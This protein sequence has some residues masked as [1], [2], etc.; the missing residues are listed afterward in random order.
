[1]ESSAGTGTPQPKYCSVA[2]TL[3]PPSWTGPAPPWELSCTCPFAIQEP[4]LTRH[5]LLTRYVSYQPCLHIADSAWQGPGWLGRVGDA[6]DTW[7]LA[8]RGPDGF[9]YRA[10]RK[11][12]P[13][14]ERQGALLVEF[15]VPLITD[16]KLP[17]QWQSMVLEEDV[18]QC[19]PT[20]DYSLEPG[21]KVLAPWEPDQQRYGPGTVLLGSEAREPQQ[22]SKGGEITVHFWNG[23]TATVPLG[24]VQWVPLAVWKKAVERLHKPLIQEH[25]RPLLW[26]PCCS[27]W[28]PATG[29]V[30]SG[31][32]LGTPFPCP[33]CVPPAC[34]Q[35]LCQ[36]CLCCCSLAGPTWWPLT[37][38][39]GGTAKEC[40][41]VEPKPPTQLL[42]LVHPKEDEASVRA[43]LGVSS[44]SSSSSEKDLE[45]DLQMGLPQRLMVDGTVNTDLVLPE[46][47]P[48]RQG[49]L[50]QPG[51]RYWR[52]GSEP[53][54][55]K[56]GAGNGT[57]W[58]EK[59]SNKEQRVQAIVM[60]N[61]R[62]LVLE[63]NG[64]KPPHIL[65]Q[66]EHRKQSQ[67]TATHQRDQN[68]LRPKALRS[69]VKSRMAGKGLPK[70]S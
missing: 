5:N 19:L 34:C 7:V 15:E 14:L 48:R 21:D 40:S 2:T 27:L 37:R 49:G 36:G 47:C 43:P 13:E 66:D 62:E 57:I 44:S 6:A 16:P 29:C 53:H 25:P 42:P 50:H 54:P 52:N 8:R 56:L 4:W 17:A 59:R 39:S 20:M 69:Q 60:G 58:K 64:V 1:M 67:A 46:K 11:A 55:G 65:P 51:W 30:T 9:Y 35:L 18:I 10:Q 23:N 28:G 12:A 45:T 61:T 70:D 38:T 33:P 68:A 31:P 32:S 24:R 22:A 41:E 26:A 3:K 63:A